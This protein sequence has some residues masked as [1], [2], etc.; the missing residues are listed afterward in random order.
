[1]T[2]RFS[3]INYSEDVTIKKS[4][5]GKKK[6]RSKFDNFKDIDNSGLSLYEKFEYGMSDW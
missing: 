3:A 4:P 2:K 5:K 6:K 1:M